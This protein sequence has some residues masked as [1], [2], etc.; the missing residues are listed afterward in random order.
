MIFGSIQMF[1]MLLHAGIAWPRISPPFHE[2]S[3]GVQTANKITEQMYYEV[4]AAFWGKA[5][6]RLTASDY[7]CP[8]ILLFSLYPFDL[9]EWRS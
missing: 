9:V 5:R 3:E 1:I 7:V 4:S 6:K 2:I 8:G